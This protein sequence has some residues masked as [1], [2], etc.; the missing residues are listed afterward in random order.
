MIAPGMGAGLSL[1][2]RLPWVRS[3]SDVSRPSKIDPRAERS[4]EPG[5]ALGFS[6]AVDA[7]TR[8]PDPVGREVSWRGLALMNRSPRE[9]RTPTVSG[10]PRGARIQSGPSSSWSSQMACC[11]TAAAVGA[12]EEEGSPSPPRARIGPPPWGGSD[13]GR[14]GEAIDVL[15]SLVRT[16]TRAGDPRSEGAD[17]RCGSPPGVSLEGSM[18]AAK[19]ALLCGGRL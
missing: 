7:T 14:V 2:P 1:V 4:S 18:A 9:V 8:C 13:D 16:G 17:W 6:V 5:G 19:A 15:P 3:I 11:M 10:V 12:F